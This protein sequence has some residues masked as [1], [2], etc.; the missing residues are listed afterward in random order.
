MPRLDVVGRIIDKVAGHVD[1]FTLDKEE[2]AQLI[3][4]INK[5]QYILIIKTSTNY[6]LKFKT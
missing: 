1:K 5:A 3:Q 2:K 4:E 6:K